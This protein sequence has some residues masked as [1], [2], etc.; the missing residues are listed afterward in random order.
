M[1][2]HYPRMG[3]AMNK[4]IKALTS[5]VF[6]ALLLSSVPSCTIKAQQVSEPPIPISIVCPYHQDS[7]KHAYENSIVANGSALAYTNKRFDTL[8]TQAQQ[9]SAE[10][11]AHFTWLYTLIALLGTMNIILLFSTSRIRKEL[12]QLKRLDHHR[13]LTTSVQPLESRHLPEFQEALFTQEPAEIHKPI[14]TRRTVAKKPR[15]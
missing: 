4:N 8:Q 9:S 5:A 10:N 7:L 11:T 2:S 3:L 12:A 15:S 14:R 13:M 1:R 6:F